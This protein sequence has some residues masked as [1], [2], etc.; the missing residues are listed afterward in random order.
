MG[1]S[2]LRVG[3]LGT[4]YWAETTHAAALLI[5]PAARFDGIWGS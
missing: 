3:L 2:P 5:S 1:T 4:G